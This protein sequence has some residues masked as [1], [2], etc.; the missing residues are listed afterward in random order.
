MHLLCLVLALTHPS[1]TLREPAAARAEPPFKAAGG[2]FVA[3]SVAD[4][5]ASAKWYAEK[6]GLTVVMEVPKQDGAAVTVLEGGGLVVE[7]VQLD[8]AVPLRRAVPAAKGAQA[9]HGIF[10]VG[11]VVEDFDGT[12]AA[13][14]ARGV[15]I[16]HGPFPARGNQR[17]NV[18]LR[19]NAGNLIQFFGK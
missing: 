10:K 18:I 4:L 2:A 3:L 7:L 8:G 12:V 13:L 5:R 14:R 6:F 11:L 1:A 16:A 9:V 19:D 17:A 15:E